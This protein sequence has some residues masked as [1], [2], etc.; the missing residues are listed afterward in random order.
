MRNYLGFLLDNHNEKLK[1]L[2]IF[3]K[4]YYSIRQIDYSMNN[5]FVF[6]R[7]WQYGMKIVAMVCLK[8]I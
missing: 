8:L 2:G 6:I 7:V 1:F 3:C 5:F 4:H